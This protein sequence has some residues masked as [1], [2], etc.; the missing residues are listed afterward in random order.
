MCLP[1]SPLRGQVHKYILTRQSE[2]YRVND[3]VVN[4]Q[5]MPNIFNTPDKT[6]HAKYSN[7]IR[8]FWSMTKILDMEP[9]MDD[10]LRELVD[11]LTTR[12]A[13]A[14]S[15]SSMTPCMMDDWLTYYAWD[16]TAYVSF[17]KEYGFLQ[18]GRDVEGIIGESTAGLKYFA[19]VSQMPWIDEW[20]DK[21]P[22]LRIGPRPLVNGFVYTVRMLTEYHQETA[23]G[24][25]K[26][27]TIDTFLDKYYTLKGHVDFVD[28]NQIINWIMLNVLAG[29]DSTSGAM[30][31]FVYHISRTPSAKAALV[32]ELDAANISL[33]A[34]WRD[35]KDL[36]YLNAAALESQRMTPALGL[37][38][39]R[40]VPLG[41]FELPDG[42]VIPA[43]TKVG[44]NPCVVTR[45]VGVFGD[46]VETFRPERW[47]RGE[48]EAE[49][50]FAHR[51]RRMA[52][53]TDLMYGAGGRVCMGKHLA[54]VIMYKLFATLY[55]TFDVSFARG[56]E[57]DRFKSVLT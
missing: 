55:T 33:P 49:D 18:Q 26:T 1:Q 27:K 40:E 44:M 31:S 10:T 37:M 54:K 16:A 35:I 19:P 53:A 2:M 3:V 7:P 9:L 15:S 29:G 14:S 43:G 12:F 42:R 25:H 34:Q 30:R 22:V 32:A 6:F 45:D 41:G 39:E 56:R 24:K 17:G 21:N 47:L 4:G 20:L 23:A 48:G 50:E 8:G 13:T 51:Y 38:L 5:R 28:D 36:P 11:V 52:E 46:D 57:V